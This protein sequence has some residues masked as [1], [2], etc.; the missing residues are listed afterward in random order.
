MKNGDVFFTP[1]AQITWCDIDSNGLTEA[2]K[3]RI[4][5]AGINNVQTSLS[6]KISRDVVIRMDKDKLNTPMLR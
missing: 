6:A 1:Q 2:N 3:T 4:K 5:S